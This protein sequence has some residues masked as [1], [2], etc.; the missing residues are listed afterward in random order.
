[1]LERGREQIKRRKRWS[2]KKNATG[3]SERREKVFYGEVEERSQE[4]EGREEDGEEDQGLSA[5]GC[6]LSE[7]LMRWTQINV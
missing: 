3:K 7:L 6:F 5:I 1:M 4:T 2:G